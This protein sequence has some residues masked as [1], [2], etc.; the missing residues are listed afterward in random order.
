MPS[1]SSVSTYCLILTSWSPAL[2]P[3]SLIVNRSSNRNSARSVGIACGSSSLRTPSSINSVSLDC[4]VLFSDLS[5]S[6]AFREGR[7]KR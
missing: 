1:H 2:L 4:R 6:A 7:K 5:H 3:S